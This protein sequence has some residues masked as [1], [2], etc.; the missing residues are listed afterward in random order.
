MLSVSDNDSRR[1]LYLILHHKDQPDQPYENTWVDAW[2]VSDIT[3]DP[4]I[5][6]LCEENRFAYIYRCRW[7]DWSPCVACSVE[8]DSVTQEIDDR[9]IVF[10]RVR[11]K[12]VVKMNDIPPRGR[13]GARSTSSPARR[14]RAESSFQIHKMREPW[15]CLR[16]Q[17]DARTPI[18]PNSEY[19][20]PEKRIA[21]PGSS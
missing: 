14:L 3:T 15:R 8:V 7:G 19:P 4:P 13:A 1:H 17:S 6:R 11:F 2:R 5:G 12:N 9:G 10:S 16:S 21:R 18:D 20:R